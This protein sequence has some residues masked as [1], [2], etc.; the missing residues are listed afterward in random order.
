MVLLIHHSAGAMFELFIL[1]VFPCLVLYYSTDHYYVLWTHS[2]KEIQ[3]VRE[4]SLNMA[5]RDDSQSVVSPSYS[6]ALQILS[7][8]QVDAL[9]KKIAR[10]TLI[11]KGYNFVESL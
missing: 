6:T 8:I 10:H 9:T 1:V 4:V 7:F 11:A 2:D 3:Q 5:P